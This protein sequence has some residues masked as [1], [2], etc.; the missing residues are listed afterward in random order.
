MNQ[1]KGSSSSGKRSPANK[2]DEDLRRD[3]E[4][5]KH[6]PEPEE[7]DALDRTIEDSFPASDPP[8]SIP[9]PDEDAA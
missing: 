4:I 8:S 9:D 5:R 6:P 1:Q 7:E 2:T 3:E